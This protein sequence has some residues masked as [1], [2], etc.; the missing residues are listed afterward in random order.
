M[1][2]FKVIDTISAWQ[3]ENGDLFEIEGSVYR[4]LAI[5]DDYDNVVD[6][7]VESLD[8]ALDDDQIILD[9]DD[10]IRL[11]AYNYDGIEV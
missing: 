10:E 11:V 7:M 3:L 8:D 4:A 1:N 9:P 2:D 5:I 6:I